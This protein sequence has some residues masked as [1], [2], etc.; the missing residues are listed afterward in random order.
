MK[1]ARWLIVSEES[2]EEEEEGGS[3]DCEEG[4]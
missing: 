2:G 4:E 1:W 3:G